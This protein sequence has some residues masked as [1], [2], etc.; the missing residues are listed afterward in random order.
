M[1]ATPKELAILPGNTSSGRSSVSA[2]SDPLPA[3][4]WLPVGTGVRLDPGV[5]TTVSFE[6]DRGDRRCVVAS[7]KLLQQ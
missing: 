5:L 1:E 2:V 4:P 7:D 6:I 3:D